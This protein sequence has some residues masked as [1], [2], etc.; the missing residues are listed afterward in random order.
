VGTGVVVVV[1]VFGVFRLVSPPYTISIYG[2]LFF[3]DISEF[4]IR[5]ILYSNFLPT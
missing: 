4:M 3:L 2:V 1:I 5:E